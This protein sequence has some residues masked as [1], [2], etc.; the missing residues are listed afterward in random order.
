MSIRDRQINKAIRNSIQEELQKGEYPSVELIQHRINQLF[1]H[2]TPG[3]PSTQLKYWPHRGVSN[4]DSFNEF[5]KEVCDDL[6]NLYAETAEQ[7]LQLLQGFDFSEMERNRLLHKVKKTQEKIKE[8]LAR[9]SSARGY[10][11][12]F[13]DTFEDYSKADMQ[14]TS[15]LIDL[16]LGHVRLPSGNAS[17][18]KVDLTKAK[19]AFEYTMT[20]ASMMNN[21][22]RDVDITPI[23]NLNNDYENVVWM[24]EIEYKQPDILAGISGS[25]D[26]VFEKDTD[27]N[28]F[29]IFIETP[30]PVEIELLYSI[31][32]DKNLKRVPSTGARKI[33]HNTTWIFPEI[34]TRKLQVRMFKS[35]PDEILKSGNGT[36]IF[37]VKNISA[38]NNAYT[39]KAEFVSKPVKIPKES[40]KVILFTEDHIPSGTNIDYSIGFYRDNTSLINWKPISPTIGMESQNIVS[41]QSPSLQE[42]DITLAYDH[43]HKMTKNNITFYPNDQL[44]DKNIS[45]NSLVLYSGHKQWIRKNGVLNS[46]TIQA[47]IVDYIPSS[48]DWNA[49]QQISSASFIDMHTGGISFD[50]IPINERKPYSFYLFTTNVFIESP[51]TIVGSESTITRNCNAVVLLNGNKIFESTHETTGSMS[52][53]ILKQG[54][55]SLQILILQINKNAVTFTVPFQAG[56][57]GDFGIQVANKS[58]LLRIDPFIL[59]ESTMPEQTNRF[60]LDESNRLWLNRYYPNE[61]FL[62]RY[63]ENADLNNT[64]LVLKAELSRH[65]DLYDRTP[66]LSTYRLRV[67]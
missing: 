2:T 52:N 20:P 39:E 60:A 55:N 31:H 64:N 43:P 50:G 32:N 45:Q 35:I 42:S 61:K 56:M 17:E 27:I 48:N 18:Q 19:I 26:I 47:D 34:T 30:T 10:G 38:Q 44:M 9:I 62:L 13:Y 33:L 40:K 59:I 49:V 46:D 25:L 54:W 51:Q 16:R 14:Q 4:P 5:Q 24:K 29:T 11:E 37:G 3:F 58:P 23:E 41:L 15:A 63:D 57:L 1:E 6:E 8:M 22:V 7:G 36:T 21:I 65:A 12:S 67:I 28:S 53:F 66:I